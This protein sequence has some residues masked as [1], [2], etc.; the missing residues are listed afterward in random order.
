MTNAVLD[1]VRSRLLP[2]QGLFRDGRFVGRATCASCGVHDE[3]T[4]LK[5]PDPDVVKRKLEDRGWSLKRRPTCPSCQI[6]KET[7]VLTKATTAKTA[8]AAPST[9]TRAALR[10]LSRVL[11]EEAYDHSGQ[12]Y[13]AGFSDAGLAK[14][15]G[16]SE[17]VVASERERLCGPA[18]EPEFFAAFRKQLSDMDKQIR[19]LAAAQVGAAEVFD[20]M[21]VK[22]GFLPLDNAEG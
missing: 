19:A 4:A 1:R 13:K 10:L 17:K 12:R 8:V 21:A 2:I 9:D 22:H 18:G 7:I 11:D 15:T 16:L 14:D 20:S 3:W 5:M 6:Q